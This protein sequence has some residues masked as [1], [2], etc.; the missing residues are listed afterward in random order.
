MLMITKSFIDNN[1]YL[2]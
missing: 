1:I 2:I